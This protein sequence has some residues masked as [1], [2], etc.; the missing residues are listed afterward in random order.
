M[1][2]ATETTNAITMNRV[3]PR[4]MVWEVAGVVS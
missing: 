4:D 3:R 1:Q 2:E